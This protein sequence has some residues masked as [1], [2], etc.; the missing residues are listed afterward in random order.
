[1]EPGVVFGVLDGH[2]VQQKSLAHKGPGGV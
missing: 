1:L 2:G